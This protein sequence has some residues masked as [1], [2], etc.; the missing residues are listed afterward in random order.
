MGIPGEK[1]NWHETLPDPH[2]DFTRPRQF[3][4]T[5]A[6]SN[7]EHFPLLPLNLAVPI[8][9][10]HPTCCSSATGSFGKSA[11]HRRFRVTICATS[12][13]H[14]QEPQPRKSAASGRTVPSI[15][16]HSR[17]SVR[18]HDMGQQQHLHQK[19]P[20]CS[21]ADVAQGTITTCHSARL[22]LVLSKATLLLRLPRP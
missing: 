2:S 21:N 3:F 11:T 5:Q 16:L 12:S 15:S 6:R 10:N 19:F 22:P 14:D 7:L 13:R 20:V 1:K 17:R 8:H 4:K 9:P 18:W